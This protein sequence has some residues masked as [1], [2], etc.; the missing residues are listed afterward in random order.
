MKSFNTQFLRSGVQQNTPRSPHP[1]LLTNLKGWFQTVRGTT[2]FLTILFDESGNLAPI[3]ALSL[4]LLESPAFELA[5]A[6]MKTDPAI[7]TIIAE[8]YMA[9]PHNLEQLRQLP[10][11][12]L[13]Y[14]YAQ[15]LQQTGFE[16][17]MAEIRITSDVSYVEYRWQQTHDIWHIITG[18]STSEIGEMGLQAFYLAQFRLPLS[19]LL[20]AN[21]L[22][23]ATVLKPEA[24]SPLLTAIAQGWELGQTAQPLLAQKWEEAWEK[25]VATWQQE[26]NIPTGNIR[27]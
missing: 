2:A 14:A 19:S 17:I 6:D 18:F 22:I 4:S 12:S 11:E 3:D 15:H 23:S 27:Q 24:L 7:A 10:P 13:G 9:P 26:L 25:P 16:P 1:N 5:I 8:R 21:A 20:I